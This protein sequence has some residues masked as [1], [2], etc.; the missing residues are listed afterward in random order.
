MSE[1]NPKQRPKGAIMMRST[2]ERLN[3]DL[4]C[5]RIEFA[6]DPDHYQLI[7]SGKAA[8]EGFQVIINPR[9]LSD[10]LAAFERFRPEPD[11]QTVH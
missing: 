9:Q 1:T 4:L 7:S 2:L 5:F 8:A 10:L 3:P 6:H 11:P